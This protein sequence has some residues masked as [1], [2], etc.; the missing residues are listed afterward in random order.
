[1]DSRRKTI[2]EQIAHLSKFTSEDSHAFQGEINNAAKLIQDLMDKYSISQQDLDLAKA[3][4]QA[5]EVK[6]EFQEKRSDYRVHGLAEWHWTLAWI[7]SRITHTKYYFGTYKKEGTAK[8]FGD[9]TNAEIA[10]VLFAEWVQIIMVMCESAIDDHWKYL[11]EKYHYKEFLAR[12]KAGLE[13]GHFMD[14]VPSHERTTYFKSSWYKGCVRGI[15]TAIY[16]Q[17]RERETTATNALV[18]YHENLNQKFQD[19]SLAIKMKTIELKPT[20]VH[21]SIGYNQGYETGKKIKIGSRRI[22]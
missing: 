11:I 13:F 4:K 16:E 22:K 10:A 20:K 17:E 18:V 15:Q 19:Y 3:E 8:F 5:E 9:Q 6:Q 12:K 14:S 21:S 1:M 2:I 7:I